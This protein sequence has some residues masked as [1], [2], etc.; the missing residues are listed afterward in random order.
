MGTNEIAWRGLVRAGVLCV[1]LGMLASC[2]GYG[3]GAPAPVEIRGAPLGARDVAGQI[4]DHLPSRSQPPR[5]DATYLTVRSGQ[6]LG[7]IAHSHHMSERD[8]IAANHLKPPYKLAAGTRL[9]IPGSGASPPQTVT[10]HAPVGAPIAERTPS[11]RSP[12]VISLDGPAPP[13]V[14]TAPPPPMSPAEAAV[15]AEVA[16]ES[17]RP[18]AARNP[19]GGVKASFPPERGEEPRRPEPAAAMHG[20]RFSWPV[21]GRLLAGYG[22]GAGGAHNDG[23]NIAAARGTP[24]KVIEG[25]IVAYAGNE[26]RGYGNL[27]LVK[28]PD[29]L[30]SAY[31]HCDELL[32]KK[33]DKIGPGQI[34]GRVGASGGVAE[35]QLHF[36]LRRGKQPIDPRQFLGPAPSADRGAAAG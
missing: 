14:A 34:I 6:S 28:H 3:P 12:D 27:V 9:V 5:R 31:A 15:A 8:I 24:I 33:G 29:G 23:I 7:G 35:P 17:E 26:L 21:Q 19:P 30:I 4:P 16:R 22:T 32:V 2:A 1:C 10:E 18:T 13:K 25:G 20:G 36:E 11:R